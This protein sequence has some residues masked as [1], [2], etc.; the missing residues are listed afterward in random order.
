MSASGGFWHGTQVSGVSSSPV[1]AV[2]D[3]AETAPVLQA[4]ATLRAAHLIAS[5]TTRAS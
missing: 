2:H 3:A 4:S 5:D 1:G